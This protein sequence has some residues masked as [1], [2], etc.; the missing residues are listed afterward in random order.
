M[1]PY[2]TPQWYLRISNFLGNGVM[3]HSVISEVYHTEADKYVH[4]SM[5]NIIRKSKTT[6]LYIHVCRRCSTGSSLFC[7][8]R[9]VALWMLNVLNECHLHNRT[10]WQIESMLL[11]KNWTPVNKLIGM[12]FCWFNLLNKDSLYAFIRRLMTPIYFDIYLTHW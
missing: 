7:R 11:W 1:D 12:K 4:H 3:L 6:W 10:R 2:Q 9:L 5:Q 8:N